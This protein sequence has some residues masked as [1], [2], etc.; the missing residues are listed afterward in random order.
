V[1][2]EPDGI[3]AR[4]LRVS[5]SLSIPYAELAWRT[6]TPGGPGGQHANRTS[7]RVEVRFDVSSSPSLG[8]RQRARL[9]D[10]AGPV[11]RAIAGDE[12][13]QSRNRQIALDRLRD[14]IA[15]ALRVEPAR[16]PTKPTR[17]SARRRLDDKR[18]RSE[19]KRRRSASVDLDG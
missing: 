4:R 2:D 16:L 19:A 1:G 12:R 17:S 8:P 6:S 11:V 9:L 3:D 5:R 7:S 14:R 18:R 15:D 10:R 13:S